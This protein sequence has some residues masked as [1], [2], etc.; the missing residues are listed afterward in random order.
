MGSQECLI[1]AEKNMSANFKKMNM[2]KPL[3]TT[4]RVHLFFIF[5]LLTFVQHSHA[6]NFKFKT[7]NYENGLP[8]NL[9]K[10][11]ALDEKGFVWIGT[12]A[13]LVR[14]DGQ[15]FLLFNQGLPSPYIK[16]FLAV[17]KNI[18]IV[19]DLGICLL[20]TTMD[21]A[22]CETFIEGRQEQTDS[23][24]FYP[25]SVFQSSDGSLWISEPRSI[26][27]FNGKTL[28]RYVFDRKFASSSYLR[29][30]ILFEDNEKR[31]FATSQ[32]GGL[33]IYR[34][35]EDRF[36]QLALSTP[37]AN[38]DINAV[39]SFPDGRLWLGSSL[40]LFELQL[41]HSLSA[42]HLK[43]ILSVTNVQS[44]Q[45]GVDN[46][47]LIGTVGA[48]LYEVEHTTQ[49]VKVNKLID[50]PFHVINHI[51][52]EIN[53]QC[54]ISSDHGLALIYNPRFNQLIKFDN[55]SVQSLNLSVAGE[56]LATDGLNVYKINESRG[57]FICQTIFKNQETMI[58]SLA[59]DGRRIYLGHIDGYITV[60]DGD[61]ISQI[62]FRDQ[63][64]IFYILPDASGNL[65]VCRNG[66]EG[67][68][69]IDTN[70]K[71]TYY[72]RQKDLTAQLTVIKE[73][74][75]FGIIGGGADSTYLFHY[76]ERR[77][78]FVN[79]SAKIDS[80]RLPLF[81]VFDLC[82][83]QQGNIWLAT[84]AG[85]FRQ[86][87]GQISQIFFEEK[88]FVKSVIVNK[89][90]EVWFG[91]DHG[92]WQYSSNELVRFERQDGFND[93]TFTF[94]S[95]LVDTNERVWLGTYDGIYY[96]QN[97]FRVRQQTNPPLFLAIDFN[98][99][100]Y[101]SADSAEMEMRYHSYLRLKF[102]SLSFPSEKILYQ[103]RL[104]KINGPW[105]VPSSETEIFLPNLISGD[106]VL[107]VR[108]QQTGHHWSL[109]AILTFSIGKPWYHSG[110]AITFYILFPT[111][112]ML[113][114]RQILLE[115]RE[116]KQALA[117]LHESEA[118]LRTVVTSA[119]II[120]FSFDRNGTF[121]LSEGKGLESLGRKSGDAV[122]KS[123]FEL[124]SNFPQIIE[125][126]QH[127]LKGEA[128][129][130]IIEVG[131]LYFRVW[132]S[133]VF[134]EHKNV[135]RVI[136]VANDISELIKTERELIRARD[137]AEVANR[138]KS[139]FLANMSH[140][141]RTPMNAI[142]GMTELTLDTNLTEEQKDFLRT[143]HFSAHNLLKIINDILDFSKIEA[144]KM[145]IEA[146]DFN[147]HEL[148][149]REIKWLGQRAAEKNLKL[150]WKIEDNAPQWLIGDATRIRQILL[151]LMNNA[152][153]FTEKG[154]I[155]INVS[156]SALTADDLELKLTVC[157]TGVGVPRPKQ[158]I[159][160]E[161]FRQADTSTTRVYGGTGLGLS[162]SAKLAELMGGDLWVESEEGVG[163][164]FFFTVKLKKSAHGEE[165]VR[166]Q[167][168]VETAQALQRYQAFGEIT[169]CKKTPSSASSKKN[170][171]HILLVE[172]NPINQKLAARLLGKK[173]HRISIAE[174]GI[175][176]IE[177]N[178]SQLF[179]I[180]LMDVQMPK[181]DGLEATRLI[182][183]WEKDKGRRT[184]I[185]AMTAHAMKGDHERCLAAG[186]DDYISKPIQTRQL[187]EAIERLRN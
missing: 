15:K 89:Y 80:L 137:A 7:Y 50:L 149:A 92:L 154:E 107:Q 35:R 152:L 183:Q 86:N 186:M 39:Y 84:N 161:A 164:K 5:I 187:H 73:D 157:D 77:D 57:S 29:S 4:A 105:S 68:V 66:V 21:S 20:R 64:T 63:H 60:I 52:A 159:I 19:T 174:N 135:I 34:S 10:A 25:K 100:R 141:I 81:Q 44:I 114:A 111:L 162:I 122:G 16:D 171:F 71:L 165:T 24:L 108:A 139:E 113:I 56:L 116:K 181:M 151:N 126:C 156:C 48:G 123:V 58:S 125:N 22:W 54:W 104:S 166:A 79:L 55:L 91:T 49:L 177:M 82:A 128:F 175:E 26:V 33:F 119:P 172:D 59:S 170:G 53:G 9:T 153:K 147:I 158:K 45:K 180:I 93:L 90:N 130:S 42:L 118:Q 179:E 41:T 87:S 69:K 74:K 27:R 136:G 103:W 132:F 106:Y 85:L 62:Q 70:R 61:E 185:I 184:P 75:N 98:G 32:Q 8:T 72:D 134:D 18:L 173:G 163:S 97:D 169:S 101:D 13:G 120:L 127:A 145:N 1:N 110:W 6:G 36:E 40:G 47:I 148:I 94:R 133:P 115:R 76:D 138:S 117:A 14:Y 96:L 11:V 23:T 46:K 12:D 121:T 129:I 28:K 3:T 78:R 2:K 65:W 144:G 31:L 140:E 109:P 38:F 51:S 168:D 67:V 160:F 112:L 178:K 131:N 143:V 176:A 155:E 167:T 17:D 37:A 146:H 95:T 124:C 43:R 30:F 142:I 182:R 102:A 83:D 150:I 99:Q 88:N